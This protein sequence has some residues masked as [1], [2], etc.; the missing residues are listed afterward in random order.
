M[1]EKN[2]NFQIVRA[3]GII[4][5]FLS[6]CS[7]FMPWIDNFKWG[8]AGVS[9]FII[10][11]GYL[12]I[13]TGKDDAEERMIPYIFRKVGKV[14]PLHLVMTAAVL[15]FSIYGIIK[16]IETFNKLILKLALSLTMVQSFIPVSEYYFCLN[17]VSWYLSL[18]LLFSV[19][20]ISIAKLI[21]K[22]LKTIAGGGIGNRDI[23]VV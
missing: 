20:G 21:S 3:I 1:T 7:A 17:S 23:V 11:S 5:I 2:A 9:L 13:Y 6:H 15:P 14:Y 12:V 16:G 19:M 22:C 4:L 18:F 10:L 8:S